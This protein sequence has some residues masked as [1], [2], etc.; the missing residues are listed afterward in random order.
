MLM[1]SDG[2]NT[3]D[4]SE[5]SLG[6]SQEDYESELKGI[7]RAS[8]AILPYQFEPEYSSDE[9]HPE[10]DLQEQVVDEDHTSNLDW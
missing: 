1:L 6:S 7:E 3:S 2:R 5:S 4:S 10:T 8:N 9:E